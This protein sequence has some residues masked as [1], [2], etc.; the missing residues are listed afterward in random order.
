VQVKRG[1]VFDVAVEIWKGATIFG[2]REAIELTKDNNKHLRVPQG[3]RMGA[4]C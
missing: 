4:W 3:L 2:N 1:A